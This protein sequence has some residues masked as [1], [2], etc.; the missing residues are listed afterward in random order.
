MNIKHLLKPL[1]LLTL[2]LF[3]TAS[4][5]AGRITGVTVTPRTAVL[6]TKARI[7]VIGNGTCGSR[8]TFGDGMSASNP[9]F[10]F[11][12]PY[13]SLP[14]RYNVIYSRTGPK[15]ISVSAFGY[16][17]SGSASTTIRIT[18]RAAGPMMRVPPGTLRRRPRYRIPSGSLPRRHPA[19]PRS[20]LRQLD[21]EA[22]RAAMRRL[23]F[24]SA[25]FTVYVGQL[26]TWCAS[27]MSD[28]LQGRVSFDYNFPR[29]ADG[30]LIPAWLVI[31]TG[32]GD[33][34]EAIS[35]GAGRRTEDSR[36]F[37][38]QTSAVCPSRCLSFRIVARNPADIRRV[39]IGPYRAC[40]RS[41]EW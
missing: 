3:A 39:N 41:R 25:Y 6:G 38:M 28:R 40:I 10:T 7:T 29:R 4:Y 21:K 30:T 33:Y 16:G 13:I 19:L 15:T 5:A 20:G 1:A 35:L 18:A 24:I 23:R 26:S 9:I 2:G 34:R 14:H 17:C 32:A 22:V 36:P 27:P 31:A 12:A 8:I 11:P 37:Y